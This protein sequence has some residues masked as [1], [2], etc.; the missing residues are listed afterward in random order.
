MHYMVTKDGLKTFF[1]RM[2]EGTLAY[3]PTNG[4]LSDGDVVLTALGALDE[5]AAK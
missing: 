2:L 3:D 1:T 4:T 5:P